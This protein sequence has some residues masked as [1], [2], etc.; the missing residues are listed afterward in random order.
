M[1]QPISPAQQHR[2]NLAVEMKEASRV[3]IIGMILDAVL[4]IIKII[5]GA[6]FHSQ[7]LV[8]D[9]I[10]SFTD[11][12][13]D[14]VVLGVMKVS[15]Q[16]PDDNHPYGHQRIETF[17]TLVLGSIL[18]AV[19]AALA[20]ENTLRLIEGGVETV[21]GWPVLVAAAAS[22]VSKE[23]IYRYTRQVGLAIR[24]DLI[25]ANAWH[26][27]TDAFSS[28]VVVVSTAGAMLGLVWLD[29]FAAVVIA[30]IIIHI[31]WKFT[32]DSVKELVD[33]G[34]S[35]EDTEM[36]KTIAR[37]TDGVR[38]VHELRSRRMGHDILLDIH[39]VVRPEISVSEGHQIGMQVVSGMRDALDNIRDI[40][41][42]I[43]AEN[44][45]DQPPTSER[46]PSREDIRAVLA[47]HIGELPSHSR[48]RL[49]YLKNK[50]HLEL[51][52]DEPDT[53]T[54]FTSGNIRDQL[55]GYPWFGSI[56]VWVA[57]EP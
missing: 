7:A 38:N 4:G 27:R 14:L 34:L 40:N 15:R 50:V 54:P 18:I 49:H 8:V 12:A 53:K 24:S 44:D 42:H 29:V 48:L 9:G 30:G 5:T 21:P 16:E 37:D 43:D 39:L 2:D 57:G 47:R 32:W 10:H 25:I 45:E 41:F 22:V 56:R 11:V 36:L 33:T 46:L 23:W 51:F 55:R 28:V 20:W 13:S 35:P 17:G 1:Q 19:G 31:G 26:S 3:T 52:L 6:L